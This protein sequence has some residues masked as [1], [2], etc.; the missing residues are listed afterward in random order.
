MLNNLLDLGNQ[1]KELFLAISNWPEIRFTEEDKHKLKTGLEF[2]VDVVYPTSIHRLM[3]PNHCILPSQ[4]I[5]YAI[6]IK[7][8][9]LALNAYLNLF[10]QLRSNGSDN[11]ARY[12]HD[13]NVE[14][15]QLSTLDE[16]SKNNFYL[17]FVDENYRF[18]GKDILNGTEKD[19]KLRSSED[20]FGSVI[21]K[22]INVPDN[23]SNVLGQ[24]IYYLS[25][26]PDIY[27]YFEKKYIHLL[28][29]ICFSNNTNNFVKYVLQFLFQY[30]D[31]N[32]IRGLIQQNQDERLFSI[33]DG[34]DK[35][36][37]IFRYSEN[38]LPEDDLVSGGK[39]R[40]FADPI[41]RTE[42]EKYIYL[43]T[44]WTA[45]RDRRLDLSIFKKIIE[46]YYPEFSIIIG[47]RNEL[48]C[49]KAI[50]VNEGSRDLSNF[51][52]AFYD[53]INTAGLVFDSGL[54][55]R[56]VSLLC[57]KPFVILTGLSGS[58]KTKLAQS[59]SRWICESEEQICLIPVG[60]DWTNR[61]P[62]LGYPNA[63]K[64]GDYIVSNGVLDLILKAKENPQ[65]PHFLILDEMNLSH[66]ERYFADFLSAMESGEESIMLHP[67]DLNVWKD[68][69]VPPNLKLPDNLFI[70]GTVNIDETTYMFSPKVLDRAGVLEFRVT[71][72]D[73]NEYMQNPGKPDIS[74]LAGNGVSLA[75]AFVSLAKSEISL[76][77]TVD[78]NQYLLQFF[79]E[80]KKNG[81]E[82][83]YRT[84]SDIYRFTGIVRILTGDSWSTDN[85]ID[86]AV[87]QKLLP[88]LHGSRKKLEPVLKTLAGFCRKSDCEKSVD[89]IL[90]DNQIDI[91][92]VAKFPLSL[93]KIK[94][95][96]N[97]VIQDGFTSFAE[98]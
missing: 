92:A 75:A 14:I 88:K 94:R 55:S 11:V 68:S 57:T 98:A 26:H 15:P 93:E 40:Y 54:V 19:W 33:V 44:E 48:K 29:L 7:R 32:K 91:H 49:N 46:K 34:E 90:K 51:L 56:F 43:S 35:L 84:A 66:V 63:L 61:E 16:F 74:K 20:F 13:K 3:T 4:Y 53:G 30:D 69:P 10:D 60:A 95:M 89:E 1:I 64:P 36:T 72:N 18:K 47:E 45:E 6:A 83:G 73:M 50:S 52:S 81:A 38:V 22:I 21:L 41:G 76:Q 65:K 8:F 80:L 9:A 2:E 23:S 31:C 62:L 86:A 24:F 59:F 58:G 67:V 42:N 27:S 79:E 12:I 82:F 28:P 85:I 96:Y 17:P 39:R 25:Q 77:N 78:I 87:I 70:I 97:R 71:K 37:S 5:L